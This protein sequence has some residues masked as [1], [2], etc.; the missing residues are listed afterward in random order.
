VLKQYGGV[1]TPLDA[2]K[3]YTNDFVPTGAEYIPPQA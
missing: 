2:Q 1:S 3:L